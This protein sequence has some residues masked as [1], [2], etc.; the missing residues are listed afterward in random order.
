MQKTKNKTEHTEE[1]STGRAYK[2]GKGNT[3]GNGEHRD[4]WRKG[5]QKLLVQGN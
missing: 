4:V 3:Q 2:N 1:Q 5:E